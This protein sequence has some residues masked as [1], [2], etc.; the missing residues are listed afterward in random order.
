M[1]RGAIAVVLGL[2]ACMATP[3]PFRAPNLGVAV[4][5]GWSSGTT[6]PAPPPTRWWRGFDDPQLNELIDTAT[7]HNHDLRAAAA[8]VEAAVME[9]RVAGA[10]RWPQI[11]VS[12]SGQR[13]RQNFIGLP[14]PGAAGQVLSRTFTQFGASLATQWE[15]DLWGRVRAGQAAAV[16]ELQAT[17]ADLV[18]ALE[19]VAAQTAKAYFAAV[20]AQLQVDLAV[21]TTALF[22]QSVEQVER[23]VTRGLRPALDLRLVRSNLATSRAGRHAAEEQLAR[24]LRQLQL[25][26]GRYPDGDVRHGL[27]LP[28]VPE[29]VP[30]GLPAELVRRRPDVVAAERRL[31]GSQ[32][33]LEQARAALFP[34]ISLTA[35]GGT[36][37]QELDDLI[38]P[39]FFVWSV[40]GNL[41]QPL[42][43]GDRL[44]NEVELQRARRR[45][46]MARY[47]QVALTAYTEVE[48]ALAA[49][50]HLRRREADLAVAATEAIA[51]RDLAEQRY[52]G[53]LA[54]LLTLLESQRRA[55]DTARERLSVE[56]QILDV[57]VDLHLAL[58]GG[59]GD[60]RTADS[61][62]AP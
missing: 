39:D 35:S 24:T 43:D 48:G 33:R 4:P 16:A 42:F 3:P 29:A 25:L 37:S 22:A 6:V 8:R 20:E 15:L 54:D 31:A 46:A 50:Q 58:G 13:Q 26:T 60:P 30:A 44:R 5:G 56:R 2:T 17:A 40:A 41:L 9:A 34:R 51:A 1:N 36:A 23:R 55:L 53:G 21:E 38:D 19:S 12:L 11:D 47:A 61:D 45:E 32:A 62:A 57:R 10:A 14:I 27:T 59:F 52:R 28:P 18:A 49:E 7:A